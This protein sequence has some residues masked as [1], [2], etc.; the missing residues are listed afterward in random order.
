MVTDYGS[1]TWPTT[2]SGGGVPI[3]ATIGSFPL[4][5]AAGDLAVAADT[6]ILYEWNG[7]AWVAIAGPGAALSLGAF[8][9]IPNADGAN[10]SGN[11]LTLEPA[12]GTHPG[13]IS[14][15]S[16]TFAGQKTFS[17]GLT[18]TLTGSASLNVLTS[19]LGNLTDAGTD[20]I[21]VTGGTGAVVGSVSLSQHVADT[22][23]NG[24]LSSTDWNTFNGKQPTGNYATSGTGD[25]SWSAPSG[26]GPVSTS[27]VATTNA[28]LTTISSL[29][30]VG[31]LTAGTWNATAIAIAH[32][33]TGQTSA[34]A[35]FNAL[36][37]ATAKGG[38]IAGTGSNAY[39]NLAVGSNAQAL[40]ADST[41]ST[42]LNWA[43]VLTNPMTT[44]GDIIYENATPA[45]ARLA[46]STS[47]S[48]AVLTQ[49][50]T[51]S[52]SAI[53]A[54]STS[55]N[56]S[57]IGA[58]TLAAAQGGT[59]LNTSASTGVAKVAAG[60]WSVSAVAGTDFAN[61]SANKIFS[62]PSSG[63]SAAPTFRS[64]VAADIS[65]LTVT[66]ANA[67][68]VESAGQLL[69]TNTNDNAATGYVG[70][71]VSG[72]PG[73]SV[74]PAAS[75]SVVTITSI[76]LTA[77]DWDVEGVAAYQIG[78]ATGASQ[79]YA[80]ISLTTNAVDTTVGLTVRGNVVTANDYMPVSRRRISIASTT[81]VYLVGQ[82]TYS[83][84]GSSVWNTD[85]IITA[86]R[87]R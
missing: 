19:A 30:S 45:P 62:G 9:S 55:L 1:F 32:G 44:L 43:N 80:G 49:T 27:L 23:H 87:V 8:G 73:S 67:G 47:A 69:G 70:E 53:P 77:G 16:Q 52:A 64:L 20:G 10:L 24:Y 37:P 81:T 76:A 71:Y 3:Y 13:G 25:I 50:G 58:G 39:G 31:T 28:T 14:I 56:A 11:V 54:W 21:T 51:G 35:A 26:A 60:T 18:G 4:G 84:V 61:Q 79:R 6:G 59:N 40:V 68:V 7:S 17:T 12:D 2:G 82:T 22:S 86:R 38:I 29:V 66:Q 57:I 36:A 5:S 34:S 48:L 46:G 42:G 72:S 63:S 78:S 74:N 65:A 33:G 83:T 85:S 15:S 41:Q 75:G